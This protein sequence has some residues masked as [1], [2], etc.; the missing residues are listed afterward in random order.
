MRDTLFVYGSFS[1]GM[2]HFQRIAGSILESRRAFMRGCAYRLPVGFPV[3]SIQGEQR[4]PG[5]IVTLQ[6]PEILLPLLDQFHGFQVLE[7]EQSLFYR[8]DSF[9]EIDGT[10]EKVLTSVYSMNLQKLPR[11]SHLILDG[12]WEKVLAEKPA[13]PLRLTDKQRN[14]VLKLGR[15]S[16]RD[17]VPIDLTLYRELLNLEL[18]VD[19]GRRVALTHLGQDVFRYLA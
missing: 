16:G 8:F 15:A 19:K 14:Y 13:L 9:A 4:I 5:S 6:R 17:I 10:G 11:G 7:P 12:N 2:V 1:Q 18:V 3:Y